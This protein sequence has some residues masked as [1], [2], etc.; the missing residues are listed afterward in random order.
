MRRHGLSLT[1]RQMNQL[2]DCQRRIETSLL[3]V[4]LR[5]CLR[6]TDFMCTTTIGETEK[7]VGQKVELDRACD[8]NGSIQMDKGDDRMI[9]ERRTS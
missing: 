9:P 4:S 5:E 2:K 1:N 6:N 8:Q 7:E 3:D